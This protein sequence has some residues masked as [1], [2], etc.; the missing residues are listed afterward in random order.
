VTPEEW[1]TF[2]NKNVL[3]AERE[4]NSAVTLESMIEELLQETFDDQQKQCDNVNLAFK[5][6]IEETKKAKT[7]LEIHLKKVFRMLVFYLM[8]IIVDGSLI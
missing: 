8:G 6:R 3:K 5:K 2:S 1:E 4:R 7:K